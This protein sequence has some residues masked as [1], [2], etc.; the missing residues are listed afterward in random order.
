MELLGEIGK[1][2]IWGAA[3]ASVVLLSAFLL[4]GRARPLGKLLYYAAFLV[5]I[6]LFLFG[7]A[8]GAAVPWAAGIRIAAIAYAIG[9]FAVLTLNFGNRAFFNSESETPASRLKCASLFLAGAFITLC[10][11][12]YIFL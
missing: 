1:F 9:I 4:S 5:A 6:A 12:I 8:F 10:T 11:F 2:C 7:D 3:A